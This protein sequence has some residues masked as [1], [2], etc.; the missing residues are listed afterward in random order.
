MPR[1]ASALWKQKYILPLSLNALAYNAGVVC[2]CKFQTRRIGSGRFLKKL[3]FRHSSKFQLSQ[4][5]CARFQNIFNNGT[6]QA[7]LKLRAMPQLHFLKNPPRSGLLELHA[8]NAHTGA[9]HSHKTIQQ[10]ARSP[11]SLLWFA[12]PPVHSY[13]STS[14][15]AA[16]E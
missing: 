12:L 15:L 7:A 8:G 14:S 1:V 11:Q 9:L 4:L 2:S 10:V 3:E 13:S 16:G 5:I 6:T